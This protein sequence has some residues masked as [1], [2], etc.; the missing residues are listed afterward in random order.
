[1]LNARGGG[2]SIEKRNA[3]GGGGPVPEKMNAGC[4]GSTGGTTSPN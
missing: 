1:M 4:G 2:G 3:R